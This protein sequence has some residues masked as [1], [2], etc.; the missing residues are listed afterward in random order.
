MNERILYLLG[1]TDHNEGATN[2]LVD[3]TQRAV[4]GALPVDYTDFIRVSNGAV[5]MIGKTYL[6]LWRLEDIVPLNRIA[7]VEHFAPGLVLFG[8]DG[9]D[10]GYAFDTRSRLIRIVSVPMVGLSL[11]TAEPCGDSFLEF[12]EYLHSQE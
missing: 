5:G 10:T 12:L 3:E 1:N 4:E 7:E 6:E 2:A 9:A 11:E 8:S